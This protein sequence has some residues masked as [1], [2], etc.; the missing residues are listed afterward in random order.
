MYLSENLKQMF[1]RSKLSKLFTYFLYNI[2]FYKAAALIFYT[3]LL[4]TLWLL[5]I[6]VSNW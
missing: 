6:T 2:Y 1:Y 4:H 3:F 5:Q